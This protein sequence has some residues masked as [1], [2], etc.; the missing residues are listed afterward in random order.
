MSDPKVTT[1]CQGS[2]QVQRFHLCNYA[3]WYNVPPMQV[4]VFRF[5]G[6]STES[7]LICPLSDLIENGKNY[8][9]LNVI[10]H[11]LLLQCICD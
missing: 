9:Y 4:H 3:H 1:G 10:V 6:G 5:L 11:Q 2:N 7:N 8:T